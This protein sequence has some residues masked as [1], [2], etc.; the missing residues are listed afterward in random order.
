[1]L[2]Y[3]KATLK[4]ALTSWNENSDPEFETELDSIIQRGE[5]RLFRDLDLETLDASNDTVTTATTGEV[6]KPLNLLG[7]RGL[8]VTV[9]GAT[10]PVLKR[11]RAWI[12]MN[13]S[14]AEEGYPVYYAEMDETRWEVSPPADDAY[15]I[16]VDG[17]YMPASIT[18]GSD[19]TTTWMSTQVP[20]L[21]E[22]A[23]SSE[24]CEFLKFWGHKDAVEAEYVRK[25]AVYKGET[26]NQERTD[27]E[28]LIGDRQQKNSE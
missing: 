26:K 15:L 8:W 10:L 9:D 1:M 16:T 23:C 17:T 6:F 12:R 2:E 5:L 14:Q 3:T 22:R 7:E 27:P 4:A 11:S 25:L 20:D 13:S 18:D 28:D 19:N 24:A 21:L